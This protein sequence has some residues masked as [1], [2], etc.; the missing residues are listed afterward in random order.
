MSLIHNESP[1]EECKLLLVY[2]VS[3]LVFIGVKNHQGTTEKK[4][5]KLLIL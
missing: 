5:V 4:E 3:S 2:I 1:N